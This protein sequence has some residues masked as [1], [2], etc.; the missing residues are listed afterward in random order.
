MN[1]KLPALYLVL[2]AAFWGL[3]YPLIELLL[4]NCDPILF[5]ALRFTIAGLPILPFFLKNLTKECLIVG[6]IL[7]VLNLGCYM[8]QAIGLQTVNASRAAF[9]TGISVLMIPFISPLLQ[10]GKP[11]LHDIISAIICM[12]GIYILTECN[13]GEFSLGDT[14]IIIADVFIAFA[15]VLIGKHAKNNMNPLMLASGQ[16]IMT[17]LYAWVAALLLTQLDFSPLHSFSFIV[18][19]LI[20]SIVCTIFAIIM[21]SK[22]QKY[23]SIQNTALIFSLEPVF[24]S[25]FDTIFTSTPPTV[26]TIVGGTVILGSILYLELCKPTH[27]PE[28]QKI[29]IPK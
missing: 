16:I 18:N 23:V 29:A 14:W 22:Y 9:L 24:A 20:C 19:L 13:I 26:Y 10:M 3:S 21:Q 27:V 1:S 8:F 25:I 2:V 15:V 12:V 5:V 17:G 7:G 28:I 6:A 11:K 4:E